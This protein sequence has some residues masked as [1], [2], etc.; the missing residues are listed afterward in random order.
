MSEKVAI[1][2]INSLSFETQCLL[3]QGEINA[4]SNDSGIVRR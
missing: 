4:A 2:V 3:L 1:K